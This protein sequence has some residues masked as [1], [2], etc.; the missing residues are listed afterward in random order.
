MLEVLFLIYGMLASEGWRQPFIQQYRF[1]AQ[2]RS[3]SPVNLIVS[4]ISI[5]VIGPIVGGF[6]AQN[7]RLGW[8][9]NFWLIFIFSASV[10]VL[11][12]FVAPETV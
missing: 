9:F 6:V 4:K 12:Y 10:L 11:G 3:R 5:I 1:S 2:V 8:R 7:P